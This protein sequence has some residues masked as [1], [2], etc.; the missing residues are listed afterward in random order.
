[1]ENLKEI[2]AQQFKFNLNQEVRHKGDNK[3]GM[4]SDMGLLVLRRTL[5]EHSDD[6]GNTHFT[7]NYICRMIRFSGSG[8]LAQF[9]E[10]EL[11]SIEDYNKKVVKEQAEREEMQHHMYQIKK[12]IYK[13]F[14]VEKDTEVY[15]IK[16]GG[17]DISKTYRVSGYQQDQQGTVLHLR[18]VGGEGS[19]SKTINVK[20]KEEFEIKVQS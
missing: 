8:D 12:E 5:E 15:L 11:L 17:V 19:T 4:H 9:K 20:S 7:R 2:F 16:N 14:G 1:M 10:S 13:S 3:H 18:E 6:D